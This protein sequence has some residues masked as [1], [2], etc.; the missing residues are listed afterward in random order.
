MD[1]VDDCRGENGRSWVLYF[2]VLVS[3]VSPLSSLSSLLS[4]LFSYLSLFLSRRCTQPLATL[5]LGQSVKAVN[6]PTPLS[7][8]FFFFFSLLRP[9]ADC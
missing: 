7:S 8:F 5:G 9:R 4:S 1:L 6:I 3:Y 2:Y